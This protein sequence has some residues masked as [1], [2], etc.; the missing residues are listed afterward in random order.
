MSS[1]RDVGSKLHIQE[2]PLGFETSRPT[3]FIALMG[4]VSLY[5]RDSLWDVKGQIAS[6]LVHSRDIRKK[7]APRYPKLCSVHR[8]GRYMCELACVN[9]FATLYIVFQF[10]KNLMC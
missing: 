2:G 8:F 6:N 5:L 1:E 10:C 4:L 7:I 9:Y 3:A